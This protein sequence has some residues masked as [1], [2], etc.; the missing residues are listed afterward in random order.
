MV[1][2]YIDYRWGKTSV[3]LGVSNLFDVKRYAP[4]PYNGGGAPIPLMGRTVFL[5]LGYRF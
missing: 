1:N 3:G 5:K 2:G 4:Q